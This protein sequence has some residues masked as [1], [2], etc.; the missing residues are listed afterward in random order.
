MPTFPNL[1]ATATI[2]NRTQEPPLENQNQ[3]KPVDPALPPV[4]QFKI[5][6]HRSGQKLKFPQPERG[7]LF[8]VGGGSSNRERFEAYDD[9]IKKQFF[10]LARKNKAAR[11]PNSQGAAVHLVVIPTA[12]EQLSEFIKENEGAHTL[13]DAW[14]RHG[15][16]KVSFLHFLPNENVSDLTLKNSIN[17]LESADAVWITG[18]KQKRL[19]HYRNTPIHLELFKVLNRGGVIGA[20]SAGTAMATRTSVLDESPIPD[21]PKHLLELDYGFGFTDKFTTDQ[22]FLARNRKVRGI[23]IVKHQNDKLPESENNNAVLGI[24]ENTALIYNIANSH[25]YSIGES[26]SLH[27]TK[28]VDG[29]I[30]TTNISSIPTSPSVISKPRANK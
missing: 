1:L 20:T 22:H 18:G 16:K 7:T 17:I 30:I 14:E 11:D 4:K 10:E 28:E 26:K 23:E 13:K 27:L 15:F 25:A 8:L 24:D 21:T 9:E 19:L 3:D 29:E 6:D 2:I 12:S 5:E